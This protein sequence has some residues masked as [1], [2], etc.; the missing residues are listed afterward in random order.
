MKNIQSDRKS[1]MD[2]MKAIS[3]LFVIWGHCFPN[4]MEALVYAFNVPVFF[5]ISGY[6]TKENKLID[7]KK[8]TMS[9]VFPYCIFCL[10]KD[11]D[12]IIKHIGDG[13]GLASVGCILSG[14]HSYDYG[15]ICIA[16]CKTLWYVYTLFLLRILASYISRKKCL[17]IPLILSSL[18]VAYIYNQYYFNDNLS[19][20]WLNLFVSIPCYFFGWYV[21]NTDKYN[22]RICLY[23]PRMTDVFITLAVCIPVL[24]IL[25]WLNTPAWMYKGAYGHSLLLFLTNAFIGTSVVF[26]MSKWLGDNFSSR[27]VYYVSIGTLPILCFHRDVMHPLIKPI[28]QADMSNV[29]TN[30]STFMASAIVLVVFVPIIYLILKYIPWLIGRKKTTA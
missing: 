14:F 9:I 5:V 1:W 30:V 13:Y 26:S 23:T 22:S 4:G 28:L 16:G 29:L 2:W 20:A 19:L 11:I 25:S 15:D 6:L 12:F 8:L 18:G 10:L 24:F 17:L 3:M 7:W 27:I 21:R